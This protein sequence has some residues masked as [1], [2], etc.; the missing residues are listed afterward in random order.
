M[1]DYVRCTLYI[2]TNYISICHRKSD[3]GAAFLQ[4][5]KNIDKEITV[6]TGV[7]GVQWRNLLL[8]TT[9]SVDK[10][11]GKTSFCA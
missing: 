9:N 10:L 7:C 3:P 5:L 11:V 4:M 2:V 6:N 8:P 1:C